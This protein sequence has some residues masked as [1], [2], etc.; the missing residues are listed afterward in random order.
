MQ[1]QSR[2]GSD[3]LAS[4][5]D[6]SP[7]SARAERP[8][9]DTRTRILKAAKEIFFRDGFASTAACAGARAS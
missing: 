5:A 7:A 9:P 4:L 2:R 1:S 6:T 8:A 3:G